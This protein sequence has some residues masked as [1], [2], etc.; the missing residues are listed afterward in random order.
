MKTKGWIKAIACG[1][2]VSML[3][4]SAAFAA[5]NNGI[6]DKTVLESSETVT[7]ETFSES[8]ESANS[9]IETKETDAEVSETETEAV[10][11]TKDTS[12]TDQIQMN[13]ETKAPETAT[14]ESE[15]IK[16]KIMKILIRF[17]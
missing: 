7:D 16:V 4:Q 2:C 3:F 8:L 11:E 13:Q 12:E 1:L 14:A 9:E 10:R 6:S 15:D 17:Q 5:E